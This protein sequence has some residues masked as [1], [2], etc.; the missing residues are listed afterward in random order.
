M[1]E[2]FCFMIEIFCFMD[3]HFC[4]MD[5][6]FGFMDENFCFMD[7]K[8]WKYA[9]QGQPGASPGDQAGQERGRSVG[10]WVGAFVGPNRLET[11]GGP[12]CRRYGWKGPCYGWKV[13]F[14]DEN[15]ISCMK[16]SRLWMK[17]SFI[18]SYGWKRHFMDETAKV[19]M[20]NK[21]YQPLNIHC[22][23]WFISYTLYSE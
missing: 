6:N 3:E 11:S 16:T 2:N 23:V 12:T 1:D 17:T 14:M 9:A 10:T 13:H 22:D 7:E 4:C 19:M 15:D 20:E 21:K 8:Y 5:E 18:L